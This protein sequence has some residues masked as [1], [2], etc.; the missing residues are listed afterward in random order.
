[1]LHGFDNDELFGAER[2]E[3]I[4]QRQIETIVESYEEELNQEDD[5]DL[6]GEAGVE[7]MRANEIDIRLD[8]ERKRL[9][10]LSDEELTALIDEEEA[11]LRELRTLGSKNKE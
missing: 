9:E 3:E 8:A 10:A 6:F 5:Y 7:K 11:L 4:R 2:L 1:M